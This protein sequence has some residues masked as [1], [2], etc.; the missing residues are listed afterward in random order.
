MKKNKR[1]KH[2]T[3]KG[4]KDKPFTKMKKATADHA[5]Q[6]SKKRQT[7]KIRG[8]VYDVVNTRVTPHGYAGHVEFPAKNIGWDGPCATLSDADGD[9]YDAPLVENP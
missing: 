1:S 7:I 9:T 4:G 3:R 6:Q 8:E 2:K 5:E